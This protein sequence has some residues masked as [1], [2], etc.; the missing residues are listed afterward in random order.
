MHSMTEENG[1]QVG[2]TSREVEHNDPS[3]LQTL[4][5]GESERREDRICFMNWWDNYDP[6]VLQLLAAL[7]ALIRLNERLTDGI[8]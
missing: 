8:D 6:A 3:H 5:T 1:G 2:L 4:D 7:N